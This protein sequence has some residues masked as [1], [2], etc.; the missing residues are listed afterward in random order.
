MKEIKIANQIVP[1]KK[2]FPHHQIYINKLPDNFNREDIEKHF[3]KYGK[4]VS[5]ELLQAEG[6][7]E[8]KEKS[9]INHCY[10][11]FEKAEDAEKCLF[12]EDRHS[13]KNKDDIR[14]VRAYKIGQNDET[15]K[16]LFLKI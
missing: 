11:R 4:I 3:G 14:V 2:C 15:D 13:I 8:I 6:A 5:I 16:K 10:I 9:N 7:Y 1:L 12:T